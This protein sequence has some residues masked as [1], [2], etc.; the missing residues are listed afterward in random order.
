MG[1]QADGAPTKVQDVQR[2]VRDKNPKSL[3]IL[4]AQELL[5]GRAG[6]RRAHQGAGRAAPG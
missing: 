1:V 2:Q 4:R 5:R 3:K 6:R